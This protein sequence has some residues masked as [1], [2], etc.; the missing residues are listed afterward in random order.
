MLS[1]ADAVRVKFLEA[2]RPWLSVTVTASVNCPVAVGVPEMVP[3][4]APMVRP[5]LAVLVSDHVYGGVPPTPASGVEYGVFCDATGSVFWM[6][7]R[8]PALIV[9]ERTCDT[10]WTALNVFGDV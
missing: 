3:V 1:A 8:P 9:M 10:V 6:R 5:S 2:G 4:F 7:P